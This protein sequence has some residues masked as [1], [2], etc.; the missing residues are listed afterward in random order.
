M[1]LRAPFFHVN[2]NC[3][4]LEMSLS[5]YRDGLGMTAQ[6]RTR[7]EHPQPGAA[8]ALEEAQWDAWILTGAAGMDGV[9]LDLLEW[10]VPPPSR[11]TGSGGLPGFRQLRVGAPTSGSSRDPDLTSIQMVSAPAG[12]R[13]LVV[14]CSD[15][16][17]SL[18]F[19]TEVVGLQRTGEHSL[20]DERGPEVFTIEL[21]G[22]GGPI[23][24]PRANEVGI[25]RLAMMSDDL[26]RDYATLLA[27]GVQP[28]SPPATLDM[29]PGLPMLRALFFPDPDGSTLELIERPDVA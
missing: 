29:G 13:G 16:Q 27:A 18:A 26:D 8:F 1:P 28:Y 15:R 9:V 7:P 21:Q 19:Y 23:G 12:V 2:V 5:Y 11:P 17:R 4:D 10:Q 3:T 22:A 14:A 24:A 6:V 20:S 25:Y